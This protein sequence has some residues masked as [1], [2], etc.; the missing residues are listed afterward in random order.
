M[1]ARLDMRSTDAVLYEQT[2]KIGFAGRL[3]LIARARIYQTFLST[4]KPGPTTR[5][6]DLGASDYEKAEANLLEK[7]YPWPSNITCGTIGSTGNISAAHPAVNVVSLVAGQPLPFTDYSFDI[8]Y[9]NAVLEHVGDRMQREALIRE[10]LRVAKSVFFIVPNRWFPV[11]HHTAIPFLHFS[12]MLFRSVL[13]QTRLKFWAR[14]DSLE[15]L[16]RA[17]IMREWPGKAPEIWYDGLYLG[18]LSSNLVIAV[19]NEI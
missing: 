9:S 19:R 7:L 11:E 2:D 4:M 16:S 3:S 10:A 6:L 14:K 5:I 1:E 17:Q 8:A 12:P 18:P 15:F 13:A